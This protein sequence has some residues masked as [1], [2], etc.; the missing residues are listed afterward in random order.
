M[1]GPR[2]RIHLALFAA[3]LL[4]AACG[5]TSN[6][7][8]TGSS[9]PS[10]PPTSGPTAPGSC[11]SGAT[12]TTSVATTAPATGSAPSASTGPAASST[13]AA[14]PTPAVRS[15]VT[16]APPTTWASL[17]WQR[18][19]PDD[20]LALVRSVV[21]WHGGYVAVGWDA[22]TPVWTSVDGARWDLLPDGTST[23]FWPGQLVIGMAPL[24]DGL[25]ALTMGAGPNSCGD[26][27]L[28]QSFDPPLVEWTSTDGRTWRPHGAGDLTFPPGPETPAPL[29][30]A[31]PRGLL[32][33]SGAGAVPAVT[34]VDGRTWTGVAASALPG[35]LRIA[36][37]APT[38]TGYVL[39]A[40][41]VVGPADFRAVVLTSPDGRTWSAPVPLPWA[42]TTVVTT[43]TGAD[44]GV[45]RL[46]VG[47]GGMIADGRFIATP[48]ASLWWQSA[49]GTRWRLLPAYPPLGPTTCTGEGCG[50]QPAG[51]LVG[52]GQ[53]ML[54]MR[55][56][57]DAAAWT[58]GDGLNWEALS[59][60]GDVPPLAATQD[61][62]PVTAAVL[63]GGV[64]V[65][66]GTNAW[67]ASAGG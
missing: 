56:G 27:I 63:P 38:A 66:D 1:S 47:S 37:V 39:V 51:L 65:S 8:L 62:L 16:A 50:G 67:Y 17:A 13:P 5:A 12:C 57:P 23:T 6:P 11:A 34:S 4:V 9:T 21:R 35:N 59:V 3:A 18:L 20:A 61:R 46:V 40:T 10:V 42:A 48:G 28:C 14:G 19:A 32:I 41:Q 43:S 2:S 64:V 60:S 52:D 58:S 30:A 36:G 15:F 53:R 7:E 31:G 33:V 25:V 24:A 54:A 22:T 26:D 44:W 45:D 49:A 29:L 55:G